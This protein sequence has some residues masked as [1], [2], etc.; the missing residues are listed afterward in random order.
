[1][2]SAWPLVFFLAGLFG[3]AL[4]ILICGVQSREAERAEAAATVVQIVPTRSFFAT[5]T[6]AFEPP[7]HV[8]AAVIHDVEER[9]RRQTEAAARYVECPSVG[10]FHEIVV[11]PISPPELSLF[12]RVQRFLD[13]ERALACAFVADPSLDRLHGELVVGV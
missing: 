13:Q 8:A 2:D 11:E 9:L 12:Q 6:A 4:L 7:P 5:L 3:C 1:M 10:R